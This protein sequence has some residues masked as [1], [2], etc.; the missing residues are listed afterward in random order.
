MVNSVLSAQC[1]C[2]SMVFD[3]LVIRAPFIT[4]ALQSSLINPVQLSNIQIALTQAC[5]YVRKRFLAM[6]NPA[7]TSLSLWLE[8]KRRAPRMV[9]SVLS[10]T[11]CGMSASST[12]G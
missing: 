11:R 1:C 4:H 5:R 7:T 12:A 3:T 6:Y 2:E 9:S 10:S 8:R